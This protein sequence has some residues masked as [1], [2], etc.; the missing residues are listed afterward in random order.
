M[1]AY[2]FGNKTK[3]ASVRLGEWIGYTLPAISRTI[4][5]FD[6]CSFTCCRGSS[7]LPLEPGRHVP[8]SFDSLGLV[9]FSIGLG[10]GGSTWGTKGL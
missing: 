8:A 2:V 1:N 6:S 9:L 7:V 10:R 5:A 4:V 3:S